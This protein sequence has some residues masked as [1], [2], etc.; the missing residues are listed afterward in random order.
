MK[1]FAKLL[2]MVLAVSM[3]L[4]MFVGA[5]EYVDAEYIDEDKADAVAYVYDLGV[6]MGNTKGEFNPRGELTRDEMAKILYVLLNVDQKAGSVYGLLADEF[7]DS[8]AIPAWSKNFVGYAAAKNLIV[9]NAAGEANALGTLSYVEAA[10]MLM[11]TLELED[12]YYDAA[13]E[14]WYADFTGPKWYTNA[15]IAADE[16]GLLEGLDIDNFK[17]AISREDV[18]VMIANAIDLQYVLDDNDTPADD[19]D[20]FYY[21]AYYKLAYP[22]YGIVTG[23]DTNDD[24]ETVLVID[25]NKTDVLLGDIELADIIGK[26][27]SAVVED[28]EIISELSFDGAVFETT[29]GGLEIAADA[30]DYDG[31]K[32][33]TEEV[34]FIDGKAIVDVA[35]LGDA[36]LFFC[37]VELVIPVEFDVL[38]DALTTSFMLQQEIALVINSDGTVSFF[39]SPI[40]FL[41]FDADLIEEDYDSEDGWLGTYTYDESLAIDPD[42]ASLEDGIY[43]VQVIDGELVIVG[44]TKEVDGTKVVATKNSKGEITVKVDGE[45][46]VVVYDDVLEGVDKVAAFDMINEAGMEAISSADIYNFQGTVKLGSVLMYGDW[47]ITFNRGSAPTP[48]DN[49]TYAVIADWYTDIIVDA[50]DLDEDDDDEEL[51]EIVTIIMNTEEGEETVTAIASE[52]GA[53]TVGGLYQVRESG[54]T[55]A[56]LN[57]GLVTKIDGDKIEVDGLTPADKAEYVFVNLTGDGAELSD[58]TIKDGIIKV[59]GKKVL[60][61]SVMAFWA[62]NDKIVIVYDL[63]REFGDYAKV[64]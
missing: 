11:R 25:G 1:K 56:T 51:I 6:M 58:I 31:D 13:S 15:V 18:A 45:K 23:V 3:V 43:A 64:L 27:I 42:Y 49:Y 54:F 8:A 17:A 53:L 30:K 59:A 16:N 2:A 21:D 50:D 10:I 46:A 40:F 62:E 24:D 39:F 5:F 19:T 29:L 34:L 12:E 47:L 41:D 33:K 37:G 26:E 22:V 35:D 63:E 38:F 44:A 48:V 32:N 55:K 60:K 52:V 57:S 36:Y 7:V 61:E 9:G 20:D 28:D 4:T 14:T